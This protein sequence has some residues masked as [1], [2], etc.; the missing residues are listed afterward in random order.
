MV[1]QLPSPSPYWTERVC[2]SAPFVSIKPT[3]SETLAV[4][5]QVVQITVM[6][7]PMSSH[8]KKT[9]ERRDAN[10]T[11][12]RLDCRLQTELDLISELEDSFH[13]LHKNTILTLKHKIKNILK[14]KTESSKTQQYFKATVT[15]KKENCLV[16]A[17]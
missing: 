12:Q 7:D 16:F 11:L 14:V 1:A 15:R 10:H 5:L 8:M 17:D 13:C 6:G 2:R 9:Q 3:G 4:P